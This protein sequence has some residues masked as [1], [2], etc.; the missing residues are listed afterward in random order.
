MSKFVIE[1]DIPAPKGRNSKYPFYDMEVG[2]SFVA[3]GT[4][5]NNLSAAASA[6]GR[7]LRRKFVTADTENGPRV[8]RVE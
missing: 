5:R 2:D 1:K 3:P 6:A 8:W 7:K 4:S